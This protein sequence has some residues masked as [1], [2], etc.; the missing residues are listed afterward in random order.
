MNVWRS[1][2]VVV[3]DGIVDGNNGPTSMCVMF[4]G[5]ME[6]IHGGILEN[7]EARNCQGCFAAY[8]ANYLLQFNN[9]CANSLCQPDIK[10]VRG[11]KKRTNY[12][13]AGAN[14]IEG[15]YSSNIYVE[16]SFYTNKCDDKPWPA[17][18]LVETVPGM[19][20]VEKFDVTQKTD[21]ELRTPITVDF[22]WDVCTIKVPD[23][24]CSQFPQV[25]IGGYTK[26]ACN[27][28]YEGCVKINGHLDPQG[29][30]YPPLE[31]E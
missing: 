10:G 6:G 12:W 28:N 20:F 18:L 16:N 7:V 22:A 25:P 19:K 23:V 27:T 11:G 30:C 29:A 5:S 1:S 3:K 13:T 31:E 8:P 21:Y 24:D 9:V 26:N 15:V 17:P 14:I 2:H 4:E